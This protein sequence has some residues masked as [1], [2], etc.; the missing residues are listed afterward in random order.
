MLLG[1]AGYVTNKPS[2]TYARQARLTP[3]YL[4]I[5]SNM[6]CNSRISLAFV[7]SDTMMEKWG[8]ENH[9]Q[10]SSH[11]MS[12][13]SWSSQQQSSVNDNGYKMK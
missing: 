3:K 2:A 8:G 5:K 7:D 11:N 6:E 1:L 9:G 13:H 12:V 10:R 4:C